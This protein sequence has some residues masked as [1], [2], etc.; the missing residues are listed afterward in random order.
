[1]QNKKFLEDFVRSQ[2][3][4]AKE[5]DKIK[6]IVSENEIVVDFGYWIFKQINHSGIN[7]EDYRR[8]WD[9]MISTML[10]EFRKNK[11]YDKV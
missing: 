6:L 11:K 9:L 1:M 7:D 3:S 10:L 2:N 5:E 8:F 4:M